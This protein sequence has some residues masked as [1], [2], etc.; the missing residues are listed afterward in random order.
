VEAQR[1]GIVHVIVPPGSTLE[2]I[3]EA[4]LRQVEGC[5]PHAVATTKRLLEHVSRFEVSYSEFAART[6]VA[7]RD[8]CDGR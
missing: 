6:Y 2:E 7:A 8:T 5:D 4:T 1:L 3:I